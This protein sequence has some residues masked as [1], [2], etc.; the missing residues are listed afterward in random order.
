M[1]ILIIT[2]HADP[3]IAPG[4][5]EGGGTHMYINELINLMIYK[6]VDSFFITR[7]A[8]KGKAFFEYGSVKLKRIEIGPEAPWN[9]DN[10]DE[11]EEEI[12]IAINNEL[13]LQGFIPDLI[14][15]IYWHSGRAALHF[16][17]LFDVPFIHTIISNGIRK[18]N[19]GY[20]ISNQRIQIEKEIFAAAKVLISISNSEKIDLVNYYAIPEDKIRVIGRGVDNLFLKDIYD[21]SGTLLSKQS[22]IINSIPDAT[23]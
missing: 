6:H 17:K 1:K 16:S 7:K 21:E 15:S 22:P 2:L 3:T 13:L 12:T 11:R 5:Q 20:G 23:K 10:L 14:H 8:S 9:K 4:A 19:T 18:K